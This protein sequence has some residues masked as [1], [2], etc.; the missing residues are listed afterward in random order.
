MDHK[1]WRAEYNK[2]AETITI[3]TI[4]EFSTEF[5]TMLSHD[6]TREILMGCFLCKIF[7]SLSLFSSSSRCFSRSFA[8]NTN[9]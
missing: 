1:S 6:R 5:G 2:N 3:D 8:V 4:S 9:S 7:C